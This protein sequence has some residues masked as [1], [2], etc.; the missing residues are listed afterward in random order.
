[1]SVVAHLC[2]LTRNETRTVLASRPPEVR[3][4]VEQ[5]RADGFALVE[6]D[7]PLGRL[8][9]TRDA[10]ERAVLATVVRGRPRELLFIRD[11][12]GGILKVRETAILE[13]W[14]APREP[15]AATDPFVGIALALLGERTEPILGKE[16]LRE[17]RTRRSASVTDTAALAKALVRGWNDGLLDV[18]VR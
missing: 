3:A 4:A 10:V 17:T 12:E 14:I 5:A 6:P 18:M 13:L 1:V 16:L 7:L 11:H 2:G 15:V 9:P 8:K